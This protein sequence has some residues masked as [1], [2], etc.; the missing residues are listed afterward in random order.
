MTDTPM[1]ALVAA[2][3][4]AAGIAPAEEEIDAI[5]ASYAAQR[6]GFD[7]MH[8]I[9]ECRYEEPALVFDP[10]PTFADWS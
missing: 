2:K 6:P 8:A 3:L 9:G 10:Q 4:A 1:R 5:A 7:A